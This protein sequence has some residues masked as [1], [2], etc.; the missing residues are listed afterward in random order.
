MQVS[1]F[2]MVFMGISAIVSIGL[3]IILFVIFYKKYNA[4]IT[5][6]IV[7]IA[8]F[9]LFA[10]VLERS[11]H[12]IVLDKFALREKPLVYII[13]GILMA[14]TFEE[15]ARFVSFRILKKK[16]NGIGTG[17]AY[18]IGHGGIE[19]ILLAGLSMINAIIFSIILNTGNIETIT[20]KLQ[21]EA[22]EQIN[23][24]ITTLLTT[25]PYLFLV[26]G[27]ERVFAI[28]IQLSLSIIV[29]Y[30]VYGKNKL[31]LYPFAIILHAIVDIPAAAMQVGV[32]KNIVL[33]ELL[34]LLGT[35]GL[36]IM[37]K[38]I[39]QRLKQNIMKDGI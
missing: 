19:A 26:S 20:G 11:I 23:A 18:G 7:G 32:I 12:T 25:S 39:H 2:S 35:I 8:G 1:I 22:L 5:P 16:H 28:C 27:I 21:G 4:K 30:S 13:Y 14:G 10:L 33:V 9:V 15:T 36:T 31:W 3:P 37:A 38:Y 17:L 6:M 34:L 29:F 24:Q